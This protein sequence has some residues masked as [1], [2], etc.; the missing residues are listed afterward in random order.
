M[1]YILIYVLSGSVAGV[2]GSIEFSSKDKCEEAVVKLSNAYAQYKTI[3][4]TKK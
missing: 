1:I 3:F 2:S 4:C